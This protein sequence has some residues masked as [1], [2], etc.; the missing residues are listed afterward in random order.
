M[1]QNFEK[2]LIEKKNLTVVGLDEVGRGALAGPVVVSAVCIKD[3]S[4]FNK[5]D[6]KDSKKTTPKERKKLADFFMNSSFLD[7][8]IEKINSETIDRI[9]ILEATK[10]AMRK[11]VSRLEERKIKIDCL[12]IDGNFKIGTNKK[13][14][15]IIKGDEKIVSC[16]IA[17]IIAKVYR[18]E[19]MEKY[20]KKY[21][22]YFFN[23]NKGY[24]TA[25]HIEA[26]KKFNLS[27]IHRKTFKL[28]K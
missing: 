16:R 19:L 3:F 5:I 26:I 11:A 21:P 17:S 10:K 7:Y 18:D 24:G 20:S 23:E 25:K 22:L 13:E 8:S 9:N 27:P 4:F 28:K 12:L 2:N 15:S 1:N 14:I 6:F